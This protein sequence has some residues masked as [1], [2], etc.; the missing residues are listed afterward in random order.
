MQLFFDNEA[1]SKVTVN[2]LRC[3]EM[4]NNF[5]LPESAVSVLEG[6]YLYEID[7]ELK[8][9]Y[10]CITMNSVEANGV[11]LL[12]GNARSHKANATSGL[13]VIS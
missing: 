1:G 10:A 6:K 3:P 13:N 8:T 9:L 12:P 4:I 2:G 5:S 11:C 7:R